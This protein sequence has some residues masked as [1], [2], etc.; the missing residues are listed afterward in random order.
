MASWLSDVL[1]GRPG[2]ESELVARY[3]RRLLGFARRQLPE[4]I[5]RRVDPEDVVQSV[6]RSFFRRLNDGHFSLEDSHDVWRLLAAMTFHKARNAVKFH[7]R[8]RRDARRERT[9]DPDDRQLDPAMEMEPGPKE[10][11]WLFEALNT[12]LS[13]LTDEQREIVVRRLEGHSIRQISEAVGL[14]RRTVLRVLAHV[15]ELGA[16]QLE[17]QS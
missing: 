3:T 9:I 7:E 14:S 15:H 2:S 16:K 1:S 8:E 4:H 11:D 5:R 12:L 13:V 10:V 17:A 6:Y